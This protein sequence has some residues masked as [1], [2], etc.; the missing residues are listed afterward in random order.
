MNSKTDVEYN[1]SIAAE[2]EWLRKYEKEFG[3][4]QLLNFVAERNGYLN[5]RLQL[6]RNALSEVATSQK[7]FI[8][9]ND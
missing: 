1:N 9:Q 2:V 5:V 8:R 6:Y 7:V 4:E 3:I